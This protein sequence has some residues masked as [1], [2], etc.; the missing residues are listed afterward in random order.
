MIIRGV[1]DTIIQP[2]HYVV[3]DKNRAKF[4][5]FDGF[6]DTPCDVQGIYR[7]K[8]TALPNDIIYIDTEPYCKDKPV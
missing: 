7:G 2:L 4:R 5:A 8:D 1:T 3:W 6:K